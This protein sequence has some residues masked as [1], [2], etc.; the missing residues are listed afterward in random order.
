MNRFAP[1]PLNRYPHDHRW[2]YHYAGRY[3]GLESNGL[4]PGGSHGI[5]L[6]L[7]VGR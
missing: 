2:T 1:L 5:R 3:K 6:D 7:T 4:S